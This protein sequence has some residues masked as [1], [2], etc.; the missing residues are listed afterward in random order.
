M[1]R[2][3]K[4]TWDIFGWDPN[5]R[6]SYAIHAGRQNTAR[7]E[8]GEAVAEQGFGKPPARIRVRDVT[9]Q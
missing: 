6:H 7:C 2:E 9:I 1:R 5:R 3:L 4:A 8:D